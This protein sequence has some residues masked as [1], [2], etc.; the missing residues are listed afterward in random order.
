MHR[1]TLRLCKWLVP[2]SLVALVGCSN[3]TD[4]GGFQLTY[5]TVLAG[6]ATID[7]LKYDNGTGTL[8]K[9][10]AP[11]ANFAVSVSVAPGATVEA[12]LFGKGT[13]AGTAK[14]VAV[15]MTATGA[16]SGDSVTATTAAATA[17]T[18]DLPSRHI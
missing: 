2:L 12:H 18:V 16:V 9:V 4:V 8:V 6:I 1:H 10:T 11:A 13:A 17:F 15:W 14:F 5:R 7:S 3:G